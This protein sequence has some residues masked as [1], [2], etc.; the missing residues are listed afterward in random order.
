MS[1]SSES[2]FEVYY[3]GMVQN[4]DLGTNL[5]QKADVLLVDKVE[6]AQVSWLLFQDKYVL[7]EYKKT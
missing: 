1:A 6:E 7:V 3:L 4:V 5:S 2:V